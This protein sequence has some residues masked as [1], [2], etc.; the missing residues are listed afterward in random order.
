VALNEVLPQMPVFLN[1]GLPEDAWMRGFS[2]SK[3]QITEFCGRTLNDRALGS[4]WPVYTG[5]KA[6]F[7]S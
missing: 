4:K 2:N 1:L 7:D 3:L 5:S 6:E